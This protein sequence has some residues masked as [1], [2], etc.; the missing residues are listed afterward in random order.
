[1]TLR[2]SELQNERDTAMKD[3]ENLLDEVG[4]FLTLFA[5]ELKLL[6]IYFDHVVSIVFSII[7][8]CCGSTRNFY[9][10]QFIG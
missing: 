8:C 6:P 1:M 5:V 7:D 10:M 3:K 4:I 9:L 2:V